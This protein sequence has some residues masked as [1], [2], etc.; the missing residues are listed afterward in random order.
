MKL[1][2][3]RDKK[4]DLTSQEKQT[5]PRLVRRNAFRI[6]PKPA[7]R[8][9]VAVRRRRFMGGTKTSGV[10]AMYNSLA[11]MLEPF[12]ARNPFLPGERFQVKYA[13]PFTM[14]TGNNAFGSQQALR[15]NSIY[16]PNFTGGGHSA[17]AYAELSARY[18]KYRVDSITWRITLTTPG[19]THDQFIAATIAPN[20]SGGISGAAIYNPL[21]DPSCTWGLMSSQGDRRAVIG[22]M[23]QL[24]KICGVTREKYEAD[25]TYS[26]N[27]GTNPAQAIYLAF[28]TASADGTDN[29]GSSAMV[30]II[31]NVWCYDRITTN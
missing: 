26:S 1:T 16:D 15:L 18:G 31:Y 29:L 20:T 8:R 6:A 12:V 3:R 11:G 13:E 28:A 27:M 19:S 5:M 10:G 30:E 7:N 21:E 25:D 22:G 14:T 23:R 24:N 2:I 4:L 9:R 17:Y